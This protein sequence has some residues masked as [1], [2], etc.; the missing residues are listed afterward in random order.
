MANNAQLL[1][2]MESYQNNICFHLLRCNV[3]STRLFVV[4]S[5]GAF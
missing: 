4:S 3:E 2:K 5:W 1:G